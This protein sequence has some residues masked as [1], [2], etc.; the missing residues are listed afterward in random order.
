[1]SDF[2]HDLLVARRAIGKD[3]F[4]FPSNS[5][6]GHIVEPRF[7]LNLVAAAT[8]I[9]VSA[10]DLRR[11]YITAAE[12]AAIS[13]Y[14][15]K[16]LVNHSLGNDVTAGYVQLSVHDLRDPAQRVADRIKQLCGIE[17]ARPRNV[18]RLKRVSP[19]PTTA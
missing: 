3:K 18:A 8:G 16:A 17:Q 5:S 7:P 15:L 13:P 12:G 10:H 11:V 19:S 1:M 9:T 4:V 14:A 2:V 6:A